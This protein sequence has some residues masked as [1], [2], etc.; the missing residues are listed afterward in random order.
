MGMF[1]H[2]IA[3][4]L[5]PGCEG[6]FYG[7]TKFGDPCLNTYT[8]EDEMYSVD[9]SACADEILICSVCKAGVKVQIPELQK[10]KVT[11]K[12]LQKSIR[13]F[14]CEEDPKIADNL[15][16]V[17][18]AKRGFVTKEEYI[19]AERAAGLVSSVPGEPADTKFKY[20]TDDKIV[21][22]HSD[23]SY[24]DQDEDD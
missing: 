16:R 20:K 8:I 6:E 2:I 9:A 10:V 15:Q 1:D 22:G 24:H 23:D 19:E 7:Q 17:L 18:K 5:T 14:V 3:K 13:Y 4:C 21:F 12:P 11:L